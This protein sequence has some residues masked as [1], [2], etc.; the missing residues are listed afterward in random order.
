MGLATVPV[1]AAQLAEYVTT[2]HRVQDDPLPGVVAAGAVLK[3][4]RHE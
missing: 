4:S 3:T 1:D 2:A